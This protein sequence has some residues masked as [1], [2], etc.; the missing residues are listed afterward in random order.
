MPVV[1]P[2]AN[3]YKISDDDFRAAWVELIRRFTVASADADLPRLHTIDSL[4]TIINRGHQLSLEYLCRMLV[5]NGYRNTMQA[6]E[7]FLAAN[8]HIL[9]PISVINPVSGR[10][11]KGTQL[12][13]PPDIE[14]AFEADVDDLEKTGV[15][16][17]DSVSSSGSIEWGIYV[18][19]FVELIDKAPY[20]PMYR[21]RPVGKPVK[22]WDKRLQSYFWPNPKVGLSATEERLKPILSK[23]KTLSALV[24]NDQ[25]WT[26]THQAIAVDVANEIFKWGG[27]PQD[28]STVTSANVRKV[29]KAAISGRASP[30][31][32]MN[33]GWT[34]VAAFATA[35]L[36]TG[37][38][39]AAPQV[40]WDSRVSASV[41]RR[42][43][44]IFH[45]EGLKSLPIAYA[46]IGLVA[47]QGGTRQNPP[48]L[49][50]RWS[51]GYGRWDTQF[52]GSAFVR[53]VCQYLNEKGMKM[54]RT[55]GKQSNWTVRGVEMVL[56]GD[57][58]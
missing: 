44:S 19:K 58:Y 52:A 26:E 53:A 25:P 37:K 6:T 11:V 33:S 56:F 43:D 9:Q 49:N 21:R 30:D 32:L 35:H 7:D 18:A 34:K 12:L 1:F 5:P 13:T 22:G 16:F 14:A 36:D 41:V 8:A 46:S 29:F 4:R 3:G 15:P 23:S 17:P 57:G 45:G 2:H 10:S 48:K 28:P 20:Q 31:T 42:L 27:V 38:P 24:A 55:D 51:N 39:H 54:T 50:L 40:I 47:G